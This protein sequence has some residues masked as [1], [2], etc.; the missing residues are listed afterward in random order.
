MLIKT[1]P[2]VYVNVSDML[3]LLALKAAYFDVF[4]ETKEKVNKLIPDFIPILDLGKKGERLALKFNFTNYIKL[5]N[6]EKKLKIV[7][8]R[9]AEYR[10]LLLSLLE[11]DIST[12]DCSINILRH[13]LPKQWVTDEHCNSLH[14]EA[15]D[16][17]L[18]IMQSRRI[19]SG[20]ETVLSFKEAG[21][22]YT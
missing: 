9:V 1:D 10:V 21:Q 22:H 17:V 16:I 11:K 12:G 15:E 8:G 2:S 7:G 18:G 6:G 14:K 3:E 5:T 13:M 19:R 20:G 4:T